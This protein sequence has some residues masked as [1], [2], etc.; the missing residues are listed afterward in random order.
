MPRL[1]LPGLASGHDLTDCLEDVG[2]HPLLDLTNVTTDDVEGFLG[3]AGE[4]FAVHRATTA[5]RPNPADRYQSV[6]ELIGAW[7]K[8][9]GGH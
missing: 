4:V 6:A 8:A 1:I 7:H 9:Q 3:Q 5:T 2:S